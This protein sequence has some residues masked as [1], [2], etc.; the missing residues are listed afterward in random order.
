MRP[1]IDITQ[2]DLAKR[3]LY[4]FIDGLATA[5]DKKDQLKKL[6][7][8]LEI[9]LKEDSEENINEGTDKPKMPK[10]VNMS[11][12]IKKGD[13]KKDKNQLI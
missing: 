8:D 11:N 4:S 1:K 10:P 3:I 12:K 2:S 7:N 6:I 13:K 5:K 9:S